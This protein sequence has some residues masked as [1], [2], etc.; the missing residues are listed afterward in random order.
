MADSIS[1]ILETQL[2]FWP[3][4]TKEEQAQMLQHCK[5]VTY[6]AG[7]HVHG[8]DTNCLGILVL[9]KGSLRV[10]LLS[11]EGK[12]VTIYHLQ[13]GDTCVLAA[14]CVL[15]GITFD[16]QIEADEQSEVLL[17]LVDLFSRLAEHNV[18]VENFSYKNA[19][20]RFS[21]VIN[22]VQRMLF[23]TLE[24]RLAAFLIDTSAKT[25]KDDIDLTHEKIARSIGS[26][27]EAVSRMLKQMAAEGS[28]ELYRG[29]VK[30]INKN[31]LYQS[32]QNKN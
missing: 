16:V 32:L 10:Y 31:S 2:P 18:Y 7:Q 26:A 21:D 28:V 25:G 5:L 8:G 29:G 14:S 27:R 30:I 23:L 3:Y 22:A 20:E 19:V 15:E 1:N 4:L 24:Q 13:H 9:Q 6:S 17:I 11:E 12:D